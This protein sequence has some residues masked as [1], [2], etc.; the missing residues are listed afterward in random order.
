MGIDWVII[1][2]GKY[3]CPSNGQETMPKTMVQVLEPG[4][5]N[6]RRELISAEVLAESM[7]Y[8]VT[9]SVI[10]SFKSFTWH[11]RNVLNETKIQV[12]PINPGCLINISS[13]V[14]P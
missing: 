1:N 9:C 7:F 3:L 2:L 13:Q 5:K 4:S 14:Y 11:L 8:A 6:E 12:N 10:I